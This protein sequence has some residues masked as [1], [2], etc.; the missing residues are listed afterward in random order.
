VTPGSDKNP[1]FVSE[2]LEQ[3]GLT[4][5]DLIAGG[6]AAVAATFAGGVAGRPARAAPG[7]RFPRADE[8]DAAVATAWLDQALGLVRGTPGFSPP[9]ASRAFCYA[10]IALYEALLPGLEGY[11]SLAGLLPG[12]GPLPAAGRNAAY[13]WPSVANAAL[14]SIH[15]S[16]FP[17]APAQLQAAIDA[18]E[19]G[20][21]RSLR[22]SL[23]PGIQARSVQRGRVV[24]SAIF[25]WS[26]GD[27]GHEGYLR[28]FP[29]YTRPTG[30]GPWVPTPP[31][32]SSALQPFWG[33]NRCFAIGT[34]AACPPGDPPAYS[35]APG[36][37][38]HAQAI[39][40]YDAVNNLTPEQEAI[41]RF[42]SDEPGATPTPLGHSVSIATQILRRERASLVL[43]AE[44]YARVGIAVADA[45][46]ACWYQ[47]YVYNL[48]RPV[49]YL[50][51]FVDS[52]WTPLLVTP[53]FPEY[54][55]GHSVQSA[56]AF[57]VLTDLFGEGYAFVDHTHDARGLQPRG[58]PSLLAAADEAAISR[59]YGG[60]HFRAA[61]ANGVNQGRCLG[62]AASALPLRT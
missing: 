13:D 6:G 34:A 16:L 29:P 62:S 43:A 1:D 61:I 40:V 41:A 39:E 9:V 51:L 60:I 48:L 22:P 12:L 46:L 26:K 4:R 42:W 20:L 5:R 24:A 14:A 49:T 57:Q 25:E 30:P 8:F 36:S 33:R 23:P 18:L 50:R 38:F 45:F 7:A 54:P 21:E 10:G 53:P 55:S 52:D 32:F 19:T 2:D 44:V 59:L 35:E 17:T 27:G 58:F 56:A 37:A 15:R 28:N 47:K 11:R 31:A 3:R